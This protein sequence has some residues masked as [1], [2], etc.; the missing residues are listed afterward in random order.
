MKLRAH[1][2]QTGTSVAEF[3]RKIG[4]SKMAVQHWVSGNRIPRPEIMKR[5]TEATNGA[6]QPNDFFDMG[7]SR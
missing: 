7:V 3:S 5:I 1:L 4:V 2:T 6:V